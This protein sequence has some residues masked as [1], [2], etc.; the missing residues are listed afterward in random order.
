MTYTLRD[1]VE[2][3][4][5]LIFAL[6]ASG[7]EDGRVMA[8][9]RY[10]RSDDGMRKVGTGE[11]NAHLR[12]DHPEYLF[13]SARRDVWLHGVPIE[14]IHRHYRP[15]RRLRQLLA[16]DGGDA[17][18]QD[19]KRLCA[20][21]QAEGFDLEHAGVTGS[22]LIGAQAITSDI[23]LVVYGS[24]QFHGARKI[25]KTLIEAGLIHEPNDALWQETYRRRGCSLDFEA[26]LWHE[27]RK[28]NKGAVN[29]RKFDISLVSTDVAAEEPK[30]VKRGQHSLQARVTDD[31]RTFHYPARYPLDHPEI[32][33]AVSFTPT[34]AGQAVAGEYVEV[35]GSLEE[36]EDGSKR[37]VVG[38]SR[39]APGEYI[40]VVA[41][42]TN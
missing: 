15:Q 18:E 28:F 33:E 4:E 9:L 36:A 5:G 14:K 35:S 10:V 7:I 32:N 8:F 27:K 6:V 17:V 38:S 25:I 24:Q 26:Y 12:A 23:D 2:T 11:A 20:C 29:G 30:F 34:Y 41:S 16:S 31:Q 19:A 22:L 1:F 21:L 37:I 42:P 40:K 39:E 13:F 3:E